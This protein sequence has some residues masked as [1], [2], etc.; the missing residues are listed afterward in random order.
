M[1]VF[2]TALLVATV[3]A[4]G[5]PAAAQEIGPGP[6]TV[7]ATI[8]PAGGIFFLDGDAEASFGNYTLG[9]TVA[10][11]ANKYVG[12]EGEVGALLGV[13][14]ALAMPGAAPSEPK[15]KTHSPNMLN[16]TGNILLSAPIARRTVPYAAVGI[17][18]LTMYKTEELGIGAAETFLTTNFG[19]G[20][21]WFATERIGFRGDYRFE[22]VRASTKS[23]SFFGQE[24]R[25]GNR[26]YGALIV[27]LTK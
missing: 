20:V 17:G 15:V 8:I 14:Q 6:A 1:K 24:D 11:N 12:F 9:G 27:N 3:T 22:M 26:F 18:G 21:K 13:N 5:I 16:Y 25:Y 10:Y 4:I 7:E 2:W 23:P 19:A